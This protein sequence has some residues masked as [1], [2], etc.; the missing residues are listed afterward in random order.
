[1]VD[2]QCG[3]KQGEAV[4]KKNIIE[5]ST[6]MWVKAASGQ[7]LPT[8]VYDSTTNQVHQVPYATKGVDSHPNHPGPKR[9]QACQISDL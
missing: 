6:N 5:S 2:E 1:M 7:H 3:V 8:K 4:K 9:K